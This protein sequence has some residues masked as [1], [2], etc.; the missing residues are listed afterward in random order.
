M[1]VLN[2]TKFI[3]NESS[4]CYASGYG[5]NLLNNNNATTTCQDTDTDGVNCSIIGTSIATQVLD[6][7]YW[8]AS[9]STT[10]VR[11]CWLPAACNNTATIAAI[12]STSN[13]TILSAIGTSSSSSATSSSA[14]VVSVLSGS[15]PYCTPGYK[16]PCKCYDGA[17]FCS[18]FATTA[19]VHVQDCAV[20]AEGYSSSSIGYECAQ[21]NSDN[22]VTIY[23]AIAIVAVIIFLGL[24]YVVYATLNLG[25]GQ[26]AASTLRHSSSNSTGC[27]NCR[28]MLAKFHLLAR[29]P[30]NKLRIPIV[31]FQIVT[32]FIG[33]TGL[34][35]PEFYQRFLGWTDVFNFNIGWLLSLSCMTKLNFYERLLLTTLSPIAAVLILGFIYMCIDCKPVEQVSASRQRVGGH[36]R[37]L[38]VL[39]EKLYLVFL[40]MTFLIYS[41]VS[42]AVFQT[43][44]CDRTDD[45]VHT[46]VTTSYLR[47]DYSIQCGT[48]KHNLYRYY[49]YIMI[50]VYPV[51][52]PVMYS[53]L[54][55]T[56]KEHHNSADTAKDDQR[57]HIPQLK[58]TKFLWKSYSKDFYYWEV[59]ECVRRLL[60]TGAVV[61]IVPGTAAQAAISC[62]MAVFT[63]VVAL[64]YKP[65]YDPLDGQIYTGGSVIIFLS[66]FL[67]LA[68]RTDVSNETHYS[69]N[70]FAIV[71]VVLNGVML[72]AACFQVLFVGYRAM[73]RPAAAVD[74]ANIE[75]AIGTGNSAAAASTV[76]AASH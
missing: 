40:A 26:D 53:W 30:W 48:V 54:L 51:G 25:D 67:S 57:K 74:E 42:T 28:Q 62:I 46:N 34:P 58:T 11:K 1:P 75:L 14:A 29:F 73:R 18:G 47:A 39:K 36:T 27:C 72:A 35:I 32:Q 16:G 24:C 19:Y 61:F 60:L 37:R 50:A 55:Y 31:A 4:C 68:M 7:G 20:C 22:R 66:M 65:H 13:A 56:S 38:I 52:I 45:D 41:T 17:S 64:Y 10:D 15:N 3:D 43:F 49:A 2:N 33:I 44:A 59:I 76:P 69:Q 8:R 23:T 5:Y 63:M 6:I 21:C 70:V 9:T 12:D 71:L